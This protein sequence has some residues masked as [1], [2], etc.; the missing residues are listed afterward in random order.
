MKASDIAILA[1]AG[2]L[3]IAS[4]ALVGTL[5]FVNQ[6]MG[7]LESTVEKT[8]D[9]VG[10]AERA[11]EGLGKNVDKLKGEAGEFRKTL[12]DYR[13]TFEK[14]NSE[15]QETIKGSGVLDKWIKKS[16]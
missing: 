16:E 10:S 1:L 15:L 6:K 11:V 13:V 8:A 7:Q 3:L 5:F 12:D 14:R 4:G 2:A 9:V